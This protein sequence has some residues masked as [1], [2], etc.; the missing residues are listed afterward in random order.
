MNTH[1][2]KQVTIVC[3]AYA[4]EPLLTLLSEAGAHGWTLF[5]VE[6]FG[7]Q[8]RR[9]ADIPE[10]AN[11]QVQV[12]LQPS[13]ADTLLERLQSELFPKFAMI[14]YESDVRVIRAQK[15]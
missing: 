4:R 14:A 6:G 12:V 2:M 1:S 5:E 15:F 10:Y 9:D 8:G 11:I 7:H 13:A 3:E